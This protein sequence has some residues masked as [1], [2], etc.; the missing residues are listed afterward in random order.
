MET[1]RAAR[2]RRRAA[3]LATGGVLLA[4]VALAGCGDAPQSGHGSSA[5]GSKAEGAPGRSVVS[6]TG[7]LAESLAPD[8]TT[9]RVGPAS[10]PTVVRLY[11]DPRCPVCKEYEEEGA[12]QALRAL[13]AQGRVRTEYTFASF[14]DDR[15]GGGGSKRAVN[16]LRAALEEGHFLEYHDAL[17]ARQPEESVDGYT[18]AYL[19]KIADGVEGLRG[20]RFDTAVREQR[21]RDF[22]TRSEAAYEDG[23][24]LGTPGFAVNG[25]LVEEPYFSALFDPELTPTVLGLL[26]RLHPAP[27]V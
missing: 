23:G 18:T 4:T 7:S 12:P 10:A 15:M 2:G 26:G 19:L 3:A 27:Q 11:E 5:P 25:H 22:V 13:A 20:E 21:Y 24:A 16:A 6:G 14:L 8:G 1:R 9:I 17:Y